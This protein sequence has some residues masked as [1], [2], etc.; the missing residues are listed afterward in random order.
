MVNEIQTPI[1]GIMFAM[2]DVS[3]FGKQTNKQHFKTSIHCMNLQNV[4]CNYFVIDMVRQG[5]MTSKTNNITKDAVCG[6]DPTVSK[7]IVIGWVIEFS[8]KVVFIKKK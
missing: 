2:N 3:I 8:I 4:G 6:S 5:L 7:T 1:C